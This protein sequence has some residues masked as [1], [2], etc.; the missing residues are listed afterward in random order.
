MFL[1]E[2]VTDEKGR[3]W[4]GRRCRRAEVGAYL[5]F[6]YIIYRYLKLNTF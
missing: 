2:G 1:W 4:G 6:I 3:R 5:I